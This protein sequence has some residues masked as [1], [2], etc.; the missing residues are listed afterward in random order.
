MDSTDKKYAVESWHIVRWTVDMTS[1]RLH[2][3]EKRI[4]AMN[5]GTSWF[6]VR[7]DV[8][9]DAN[10]RWHVPKARLRAV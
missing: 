4:I 9:P 6:F 10:R 7:C 2:G 5:A 3:C 8:L 1:L